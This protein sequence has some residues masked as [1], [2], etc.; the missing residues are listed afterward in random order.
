MKK[1]KN[2]KKHTK[3]NTNKQ[4]HSITVDGHTLEK[5]HLKTKDGDECYFGLV[6]KQENDTCLFGVF[7]LYGA[8][9]DGVAFTITKEPTSQ[10]YYTTFDDYGIA[11]CPVASL[12]TQRALLVKDAFAKK[13]PPRALWWFESGLAYFSQ[14]YT[15]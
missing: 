8:D 1:K 4:H 7:N 14:H 15:F 5:V 2:T 6:F 12:K 13:L 9:N 11:L 3:K 10:R